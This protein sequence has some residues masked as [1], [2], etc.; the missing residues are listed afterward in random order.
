MYQLLVASS[1][2][3][4]FLVSSLLRVVS[5]AADAQH[6]CNSKARSVRTK[7]NYDALRNA[8]SAAEAA[9]KNLIEQSKKFGA[10]VAAIQRAHG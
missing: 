9:S 2:V 10:E 4:T 3:A 8:Q 5:K 1:K 7:A 6:A